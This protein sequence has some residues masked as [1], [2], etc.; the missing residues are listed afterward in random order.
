MFQYVEEITQNGECM[1]ILSP[2]RSTKEQG[3]ESIFEFSSVIQIKSS[4]QK[5]LSLVLSCK[6]AQKEEDEEDEASC[7]HAHKLRVKKPG[8]FLAQVELVFFLSIYHHPIDSKGHIAL[9]R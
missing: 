6:T 9:R 2:K 1:C 7:I 3:V 5:L 8:I 4:I